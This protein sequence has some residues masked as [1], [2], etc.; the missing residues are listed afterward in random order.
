MSIFTPSDAPLSADQLEDL[1]HIKYSENQRATE[2]QSLFN[3]FKF[4]R[5]IEEG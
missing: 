1:F 5:D 3:F 2:E 4:L